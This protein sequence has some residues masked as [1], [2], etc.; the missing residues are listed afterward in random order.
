MSAQIL[1]GKAM[2]ARRQE[3]I[4]REVVSLKTKTGRAP[5]L[6]VVMV[7]DNPSSRIYVSNKHKACAALGLV[8]FEHHLK[9]DTSETALLD[10][11]S[12]LNHNSAVD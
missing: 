5:G 3:Q 11:I 10:L 9:A 6:A 4:A 2:A 12:Q 1:D 7:G 8:S